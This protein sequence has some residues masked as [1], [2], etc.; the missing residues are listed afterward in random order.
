[1]LIPINNFKG[2]NSNYRHKIG[3][4]RDIKDWLALQVS[5]KM[6]LINVVIKVYLLSF[7]ICYVLELKLLFFFITFFLNIPLSLLD[8]GLVLANLNPTLDI[9]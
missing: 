4:S 2:F 3:L 7:S 8:F 1:M 9:V 6:P 5:I